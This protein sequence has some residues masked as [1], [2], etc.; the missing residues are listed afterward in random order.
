MQ[1]FTITVHDKDVIAKLESLKRKKGEYITRLI[2]EDIKHDI[3]EKRIGEIEAR[4][5]GGK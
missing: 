1:E 3:L 4:M 5:K 2:K